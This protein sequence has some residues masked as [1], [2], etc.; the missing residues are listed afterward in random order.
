M[1]SWY[2]VIFTDGLKERA[3]SRATWGNKDGS[4]WATWHA[5]RIRTVFGTQI[6]SLA[7]LRFR[8]PHMFLLE[9]K[10]SVQVANFNSVQINLLVSYIQRV[11][12]WTIMNIA[13]QQATSHTMNASLPDECHQTQ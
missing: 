3:L 13:L 6:Y 9:K 2:A 8:L 7:H 11:S 10:L 4:L 5:E 1:E 12:Y